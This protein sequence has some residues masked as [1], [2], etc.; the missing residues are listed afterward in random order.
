P[1]APPS[2]ESTGPSARTPSRDRR[3]YDL[4]APAPYPD[5]SRMS[6][7][8]FE[9]WLASSQLPEFRKEELRQSEDRTKHYGSIRVWNQLDRASSD[10][11]R[12]N[13]ALLAA[14]P[15]L[16]AEVKD[17]FYAVNTKMRDAL[18]KMNYSAAGND[19]KLRAEAARSAFS[20]QE[21]I[22]KLEEL[23][24]KKLYAP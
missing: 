21:E 8:Q 17:A 4:R 7:P 18:S 2:C 3:D 11:A 6:L 20:I 23:I 22:P 16:N 1:S 14:R 5:L 9:E 15:L 10:C 13:N 12:F 24:H 19:F